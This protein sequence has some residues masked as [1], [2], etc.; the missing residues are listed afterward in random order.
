MRRN[1]ETFRQIVKRK[2]LR[3]FPGSARP[4]KG[5]PAGSGCCGIKLRPAGNCSM[6]R[7]AAIFPFSLAL[8]AT[9]QCKRRASPTRSA[10]AIP[11][12]KSGKQVLERKKARFIANVTIRQWI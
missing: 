12:A 8:P 3:A 9:A 5:P 11:N 10:A 4:R 2:I 6:N 1:L 7:K